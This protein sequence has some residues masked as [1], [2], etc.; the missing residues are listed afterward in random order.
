MVGQRLAVLFFFHYVDATAA[1]RGVSLAP[2]ELPSLSIIY[3][4][5]PAEHPHLIRAFLLFTQLA[6]SAAR[7]LLPGS[8]ALLFMQTARQQS[9]INIVSATRRQS[10]TEI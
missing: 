8:L 3:F 4:F 9:I 1:V 10:K 6:C 2:R 5:Y 7:R